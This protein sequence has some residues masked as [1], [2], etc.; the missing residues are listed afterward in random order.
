MALD[1][2]DDRRFVERVS[3]RQD[4]LDALNRRDLG[5]VIGVLG[6]HG[7]SQGLLA[8]LTGIPQG[9]LSEYKNGKRLP[10]L[11]TLEAFANGL[12]L[13]EP[14]RRALGLATSGEADA[15]LAAAG[16]SD[17]AAPSDLLT[18]AWMTGSLNHYV[19][20]RSVL[21]FAAMVAASPL[22]GVAEP[23]D[24]LAFALTGPTSLHDDT[25]DFL[26]QRTIGLHRIEPMYAA[27][28]VHRSIMTHLRE[29]TALLEGPPRRPSARTACQDR[30]RKR[31]PGR[32]DRLGHEGARPQRPDVPHHR[33]GSPRGE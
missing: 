19:D 33:S 27:R 23:M 17:P 11:N 3:A 12:G 7:I 13:P 1:H 30:W 29:V 21:Q 16:S 14:A 8:G 2:Q 4:V 5:S 18:V 9:R 26:E 6:S 20:R 22:M 10:T 31:R 24:R 28:L 32:L 25:L 15:A